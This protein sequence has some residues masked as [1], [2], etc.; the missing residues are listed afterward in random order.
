[1]YIKCTTYR[2][3]L[4]FF[5]YNRVHIYYIPLL[6]E[7]FL[8]TKVIVYIQMANPGDSGSQNVANS[9]ILVSLFNFLI[10]LRNSTCEDG[11]VRLVDAGS[12]SKQLVEVCI[13]N[14]WGTVS[15]KYW[16][17]DN[18]GVVCSQIGFTQ[19]GQHHLHWKNNYTPCR[20]Y[21]CMLVKWYSGIIS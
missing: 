7:L 1:M 15:G 14:Q 6:R 21:M 11:D 8:I 5:K 4:A 13:S 12:S 18:A 20:F 17:Q 10:A 2:L 16:D 3:K 9:M 19:R